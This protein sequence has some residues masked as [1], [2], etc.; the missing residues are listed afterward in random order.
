MLDTA[1]LGIAVAGELIQ[2][3]AE[4]ERAIRQAD[5]AYLSDQDLADDLVL[6]NQISE[7]QA[8]MDLVMTREQVVE[9]Q[10]DR[11]IAQLRDLRSLELAHARDTI[12][13]NGREDRVR[14]LTADI[15]LQRLRLLQAEHGLEQRLLEY[16]RIVQRAQVLSG[17]LAEL[18]NQRANITSLLGSPAV[19]FAWANRLEQAENR[20]NQAKSALMNW[21]VAMEYYAV[22]PFMDQRIQIL[23]ARNTYQLEEIAAEMERLQGVCG[24]NL[25]E[26]STVVSVVQLLGADDLVY[27]DA[28]DEVVDSQ[29]QFWALLQRGD[30]SVD[31]R[32]RLGTAVNGLDLMAR[33]DLLSTTISLDVDGFANLSASCNAKVVSFDV[34]LIGEDLG[35]G[36]PTVHII[37]EGTSR[38]RSCQPDLADYVAQ[39]GQGSTSFGPVTTF[40][41]PSRS[42]SPVAGL[43]E[44]LSDTFDGGGNVTLSGLPLA[45]SYTTVIDPRLGSNSSI[46][47]QNL[48]DIELQV[49]Y[50]YQDFFPSCECL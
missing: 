39:F 16:L 34:S 36:L 8:M 20:L 21:L 17:R 33:D 31:R 4:E 10:T 32:V 45:T 6:E 47:W 15:A 46:N 44:F 30:V 37:Y 42:V 35:E 3:N 18:T 14:E 7:L 12:E 5:L 25:N 19:V 49:N 40:M 26:E 2:L 38:V 11:I 28:L 9:F 22:R 13:L 1:A 24:G 50:G 48:E 27:V 43:N 29:S 41:S 23:L